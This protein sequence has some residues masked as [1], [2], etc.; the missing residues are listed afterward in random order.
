MKEDKNNFVKRLF[1]AVDIPEFI[2]DDIYN[3][4]GFLLKEEKRI[5]LVPA[6]NIHI[7]LKFLG[8]I[9]TGKINKIEKSIKETAGAFRRFKYEIN[10]KVN[11]FP[12][13]DNARVVFL[14]IGN[15]G[16]QISEIYNELENN[17]SKVK[18]RKDKRKFFPH[19]TI[20]RIKNKKNIEQLVNNHGMDSVGWLNCS[21]ITLF[22][23]RLKPQG[24]EYTILS[25][26]SLK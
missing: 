12:G 21:K 23:S 24:A 14:E 17:L 9:N 7:N 18:I 20:A 19:I 10:G 3:F 5:K 13:L 4:A 11:A 15:G 22:E 2:K 25:K 26:F 8:N 16:G 6:T 1:I